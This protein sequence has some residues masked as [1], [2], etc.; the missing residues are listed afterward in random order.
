MT[1]LVVDSSVSI[2]WFVTEDHSAQA[3]WVYD[4]YVAG[5]LRL[6]APDS[7]CVEIGNIVWK[8]HRFQ[9]LDAH[10]AEQV[11]EAFQRVP[12]ELTSTDALLDQAYALAVTHRCAVYDAVYLALSV[13][14]GCPFVTADE[15]LVKGVGTAIPNT[16]LLANWPS[17]F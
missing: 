10:D 15:K 8:K 12:L 3:Q 7:I 16:I 14:R 13:S 6:L 5:H 11:V 9:G 1:D 4:Q 17:P 2:K